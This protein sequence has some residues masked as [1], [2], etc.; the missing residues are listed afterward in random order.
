M[1]VANIISQI[2]KNKMGKECSTNGEDEK[3][4]YGFGGKS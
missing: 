2:K 1:L 3:C 4:V